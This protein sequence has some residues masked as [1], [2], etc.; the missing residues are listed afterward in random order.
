MSIVPTGRKT[1][2]PRRPPRLGRVFSSVRPF[3]FVTF[4]TYQRRNVLARSEVHQSFRRFCLKAREHDIAVG[5]YVVM[6]DHV[7][8]FVALPIRDVCLSSWIQSLRSV[9]GKRLLG[10]GVSKPHWQEG[11]FDHLLRSHESYAEKW[12][13]VRL[14]PV[15][16]QLCQI[17]EDWLYQGEIVPIRFD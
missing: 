2:W 10:L 3:Y 11:F 13:Y 5:R 9:M 4:N 6:P 1:K 14:N 8:L 12:E 15:R 17:A 7:H 16:A